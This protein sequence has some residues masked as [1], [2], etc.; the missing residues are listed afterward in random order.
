MSTLYSRGRTAEDFTC[1]S[2]G[3]GSIACGRAMRSKT[4]TLHKQ[5]MAFAACPCHSA[6]HHLPRMTPFAPQPPTCEC[7]LII[8]Q[9]FG[10]AAIFQSLAFVHHKHPAHTHDSS[11]AGK[12]LIL[13]ATAVTLI[14][15][16]AKE[17]F[18]SRSYC[19]IYLPRQQASCTPAL[20]STT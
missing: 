1:A 16:D 10:W 5:S 2:K 13:I 12:S 18:Q 17:I 6:E 15:T 11:M 20:Q 9:Q 8:L 7:S 14:S 19:R 3:V 4:T